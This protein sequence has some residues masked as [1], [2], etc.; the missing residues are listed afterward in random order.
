MYGA[1]AADLR[2]GESVRL[3]PVR[4]CGEVRSSGYEKD[5]SAGDHP[6]TSSRWITNGVRRCPIRSTDAAPNAVFQPLMLAAREPGLGRM[7]QLNCWIVSVHHVGI[8]QVE[9]A[10]AN[11]H[12][13]CLSGS[14]TDNFARMFITCAWAV[15][16]PIPSSAVISLFRIPR[17]TS[18]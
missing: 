5:R 12:H 18:R 8:I 13:Y 3:A 10:A 4:E 9:D 11:R 17:A 15:R 14:C 16:R 1:G 7:Q 6:P 2:A